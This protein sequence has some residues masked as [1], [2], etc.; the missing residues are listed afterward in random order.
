MCS[1][2]RN[3]A[4]LSTTASVA[5]RPSGTGGPRRRPAPLGSTPQAPISTPC[6][7][8]IA[9]AAVN[10]LTEV[11]ANDDAPGGVHTSAVAF[12]ATAGT[13][14]QIA[15][16]GFTKNATT[17]P[18]GG[19]LDLHLVETIPPKVTA[20]QPAFGPVGMN[21]T[22]VG[23]SLSGVTSVHFGSVA[24]T[25][26]PVSATQ[27][28]AVV[29]AGATDHTVTVARGSS[30]G[31]SASAFDVTSG[32]V[33]NATGG[34]FAPQKVTIKVGQ[35]VGF[36]NKDTA[37]HSVVDALSLGA[38]A[39]PSFDSGA[40]ARRGS[41]A[42]R[43]QS[44]GSFNY[45]S[46]QGESPTMSGTVDVLPT[47][48]RTHGGT[49]TSFRLVWATRRP[50]GCTFDVLVAHRPPNGQYGPYKPFLQATS[51][52]SAHFVANHGRGDY[53]F[54]ARLVRTSTGRVS[55]YSG[56]RVITVS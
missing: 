15:V 7:P 20:L 18:D 49:S 56:A 22:I 34:A 14:Y 44:A 30:S 55:G 36:D 27:I 21:V 40:L 2:P 39:S 45:V 16:D 54:I 26:T 43:R 4:S 9:A 48:S 35:V 8:S 13:T 53:A 41:Y 17:P 51:T 3:P 24:A 46:D 6:S 42:L 31:T 52:K 28:V 50:G 33:V 38:G 25:F 10:A 32:K 19:V 37:V 5:A 47:V 29:P 11:T 23:T 12:H 1:P